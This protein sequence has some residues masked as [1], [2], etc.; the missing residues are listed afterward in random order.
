MMGEGEQ[1]LEYNMVVSTV[2]MK[3]VPFHQLLHTQI[4][5]FICSLSKGYLDNVIRT[6]LPTRM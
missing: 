5:Q 6:V 3:L 4:T 1:S 2:T